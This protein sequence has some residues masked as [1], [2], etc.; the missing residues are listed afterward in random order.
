MV[1]ND[2]ETMFCL[3]QLNIFS[4]FSAKIKP[5]VDEYEELTLQ[6]G[7]ISLNCDSIEN[8]LD[9]LKLEIVLQYEICKD[10]Y[11][12]RIDYWER[13][14]RDKKEKLILQAKDSIETFENNRRDWIDRL[15]KWK[16]DCLSLRNKEPLQ[17]SDQKPF[18]QLYKSEDVGMGK[19]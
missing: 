12:I 9:R 14:G 18:I 5:K 7:T 8:T 1:L 3:H 17:S 11:A 19:T 2:Y 16:K 15:D 10:I 4:N 13:G 6:F